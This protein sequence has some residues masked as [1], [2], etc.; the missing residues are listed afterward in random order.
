VACSPPSGAE[1]QLIKVSA[2]VQKLCCGLSSNSL[3]MSITKVS[4]CGAVMM[5][6]ILS[7]VTP[8]GQS[9][10]AVSAA[11]DIAE[12]HN[13]DEVFSLA[14]SRSSEPRPNGD[15]S[16]LFDE[17]KDDLDEVHT[18][19]QDD[20]VEGLELASLADA[21]AFNVIDTNGQIAVTPP[22]SGGGGEGAGWS[23]PPWVWTIVGA[24]V[25]AG[26]D[27][28]DRNRD[29]DSNGGNGNASPAF[30]DGSQS[31]TAL[32]NA[33]TEI[34]A[35]ATDADGD[36]ITY[37]ASTPSNGSVVQDAENP[38][39]FVYTPDSDYVGD[40]SFVITAS[41]GNNGV[42]LQVISIS[43][44]EPVASY[45]LTANSPSV[46]EDD[47][48]TVQ[49]TLEL[50]LDQAA[51]L[52]DVVV[53]VVSSGGTATAGEDYTAIDTQLT[54][55]AGETTAT[56]VIDVLADTVFE[57]DETIELTISGDRLDQAFT[58]TATITDNDPDTE[59]PAA[60][61]L[62]LAE[63]ADTGDSSSDG[64]TSDTTPSFEIMAESGATVE[65]LVD[66]ESVGTATE[67]G[68]TAGLFTFE[69]AELAEGDYSVTAT[70]TDAAGNVSALSLAEDIT[71]DTSAPTIAALS[72][73]AE[74][75]TATV[76]FNEAIASFTAEDFSFLLNDADVDVI[77]SE[78]I[79][80]DSIRFVLD[81]DLVGDDSVDIAAI[82]AAVS[83]IAG[84]DFAAIAFA[85]DPA[86]VIA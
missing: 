7:T 71:V 43:V 68:D 64:I 25:I 33:D 62:V 2:L 30:A 67:S 70:A 31:V 34:T 60:P 85:D 29:D 74:A 86:P 80:E 66:G 13:L 77:S 15:L 73:D 84:N 54:F 6:T 41:D 52:E 53:N 18:A 47:V 14:D 63:S 46:T 37:S 3:A 75:D 58:A 20:F 24:G 39:V 69:S 76:Q 42:G 21:P 79:G 32:S 8:K 45:E 26:F 56:L 38:G 81:A 40:D 11:V 49:M 1:G 28:Y 78:L 23:I 83:D 19:Y 9:A 12:L 57:G 55:A 50:T 48:D 82:A 16:A 44:A 4:L 65:V 72:V 22:E 5:R 59:A 17:K 51:F 35:S 61:S 36:T 10:D 27:A